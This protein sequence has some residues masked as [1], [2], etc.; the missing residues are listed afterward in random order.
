MQEESLQPEEVSITVNGRPVRVAAGTSIAAALLMAGEPSRFSV[1]GE[2]RAPLCGMGICMECRGDGEW[3]AASAKLPADLR[4]RHGGCLRMSAT[5]A[6]FDVVV[7]GAG[8]EALPRRLWPRRPASAS[9][10]WMRMRLRAGKSG[11][12]CARRRRG[13][14]RMVRCLLRGWLA[15]RDRAAWCGPARRSWTLRH[16]AGCALSPRAKAAMWSLND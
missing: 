1:T 12:D 14:I 4:L 11:E 5:S 15:W 10:C 16:P 13:G 7:A 3:R 8:P 9:A 6:R 2:A